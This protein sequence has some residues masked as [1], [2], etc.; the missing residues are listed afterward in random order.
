MI[1]GFA[2]VTVEL[3]SSRDLGARLAAAMFFGGDIF[4]AYSPIPIFTSIPAMLF[5][6][7]LYEMI[8][9]DSFGMIAKG[10]V[11][12]ENGAEG[13][14]QHISKTTFDTGLSSHMTGSTDSDVSRRNM[15]ENDA[16]V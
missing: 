12:H 13:V 15:R 2:D 3:N 5:G 7:A 16:P 11:S 10:H 8:Q 4:G 1:W 14:M 6:T 9:R